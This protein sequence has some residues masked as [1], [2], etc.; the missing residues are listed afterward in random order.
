MA[1]ASLANSSGW[2][3]IS[4]PNRIWILAPVPGTSLIE[5]GSRAGSAT[6]RI[7]TAPSV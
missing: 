2:N 7:P 4:E 6:S 3:V 5:A 1:S